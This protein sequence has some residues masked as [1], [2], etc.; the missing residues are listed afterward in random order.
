M[1]IY[2]CI[3]RHII[4]I[5]IYNIY[6]YTRTYGSMNRVYLTCWWDSSSICHLRLIDLCPGHV[7]FR[8]AMMWPLHSLVHAELIGTCVAETSHAGM[9]QPGA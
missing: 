6:I 3:H 2:I 1:Y 8:L 4:Y 5:Y 9:I 7:K